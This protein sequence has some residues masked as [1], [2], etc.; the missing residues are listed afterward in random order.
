MPIKTLVS[1]SLPIYSLFL[2]LLV[3]GLSRHPWPG[4]TPPQPAAVTVDFAAIAAPDFK[5]IKDI[6]QRKKAFFDFLRPMI[7]EQNRQLKEQR[8]QLQ[9]LGAILERKEYLQRAE[10]ATLATMAEQYNLQHDDN[11]TLVNQLLLRVNTIPEAMALAQAASESAWGTSRFAREGNNY[12]GQWCYSQGCG[13]VP[14]RRQRGAAHEV[15]A[16]ASAYDSVHAYF[17]NINT[18]PAYRQFRLLRQQQSAA[19]NALTARA[20]LPGLQK[21]SERGNAYLEELKTIIRQNKLAR[22]QQ[23]RQL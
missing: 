7:A 4:P 9:K 1:L 10:L 15:A 18:H 5:A 16:F 19:D 20:L 6:P 3:I 22:S 17:R 12:F 21:Y 14:N 23:Q 2:L 11:R 13:L 8:A